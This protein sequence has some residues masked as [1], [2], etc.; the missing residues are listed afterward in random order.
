VLSQPDARD[1]MSLPPQTIDWLALN[2]FDG[3]LQG[4]HIGLMLDAGWGLPVDPEV[5]AA[6]QNAARTLAAAGAVVTP[7]PPI[8]T[9]EMAE[10]MDRFWR[11]RFW[12]DF[13]AMAPERQDRILPF[14]RQWA[15]GAQQLSGAD[16]YRGFAQMG[17][18]REA[19]VAAC[20]PF[21]F[22]ISPTAP[23]TAFA[24]ELPCPTNDPAHPL[25][26]IGFTVPFNMSEQPAAS[27]PC[28]MSRA[29]LP[30]GLQVVGQ[31]FD[32][33]GVLQLCAAFERLRA[34]LP[35]WPTLGTAAA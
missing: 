31:R 4:L 33:L 28:G 18:M 17:A 8:L 10:G 35:D 13:A 9:P 27:I 5:S 22:V 15:E 30:I 12:V 14:I 20:R 32:D 24:A 2:R 29:G 11:M 7:M 23:I 26:H 1:T 25:D 19:A 16:V 3:G 6:V 21:D 34:P